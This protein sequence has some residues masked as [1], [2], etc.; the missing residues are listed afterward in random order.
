LVSSAPSVVCRP[1]P[2]TS[3]AAVFAIGHPLICVPKVPEMLLI[4][5]VR[6]FGESSDGEVPVS[7]CPRT[8]SSWHFVLAKAACSMRHTIASDGFQR[9][10]PDGEAMAAQ[11]WSKPANA[12]LRA[13]QWLQNPAFPTGVSLC[14][15]KRRAALSR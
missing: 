8:H 12:A 10:P 5:I 9:S 3:D 4:D 1:T 13:L 14:F 6:S 11:Q 7:T 2:R 15:K